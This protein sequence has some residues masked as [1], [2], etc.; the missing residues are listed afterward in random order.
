M[1]VE[2]NA[3]VESLAALLINGEPKGMH[4]VDMVAAILNLFEEEPEF[5]VREMSRRLNLSRSAVQRFAAGLATAGLLDR[6]GRRYRLGLR[7]LELGALVP[8]RSELVDVARPTLRALVQMT[9][10]TVHL[11]AL[12]GINVVYMAKVEGPRAMAMPTQIGRLNPVYCT[13][14]G[15]VLLAYQEPE[16]VARVSAHGLLPY[17]KRTITDPGE[18][19]AQLNAIRKNGFAIDDQERQLGLRCVALPVGDETGAVVA[20]LS[21]AGPAARMTNPNI[22]SMLPEIKQAADR[23]GRALGWHP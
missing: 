6:H 23:I 17:T 3:P 13:G 4:T 10:E 9:G 1:T 14:V 7:L 2:A 20:S 5:G 19:R 18:L 15:K 22:R 8:M 11:A 12:D 16:F 21:I